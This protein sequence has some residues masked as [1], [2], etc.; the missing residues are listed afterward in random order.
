MADPDLESEAVNASGCLPDHSHSQ[1]RL[2]E[3]ASFIQGE[4]ATNPITAKDFEHLF[5]LAHAKLRRI[6][7]RERFKLHA[8]DTMS[9]TAVV[10]ESYLKLRLASAQNFNDEKHFFLTAAQSMRS[11]IVD[12]VRAKLSDKR[13]GGLIESFDSQPETSE[14]AGG[15]RWL[16]DLNDSITALEQLHPR[17]AVV[18]K[19]RYFAG[20]TDREVAELLGVTVMTVQRDWIKARAWLHDDMK[21]SNT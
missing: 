11:V 17:P 3:F 6:A 2:D 1:E 13:G 10:N 12:Y 21:A 20:L 8:G 16:I 15:E 5:V 19:L 18:V 4:L 9:T 14:A 7:H